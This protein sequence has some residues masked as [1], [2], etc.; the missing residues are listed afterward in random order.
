MNEF[1]T[2]EDEISENARADMKLLKCELFETY[3]FNHNCT[4]QVLQIIVLAA[5]DD[6]EL[7]IEY[8]DDRYD[9][10]EIA[11]LCNDLEA[12]LFAI[13]EEANDNQVDSLI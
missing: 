1:W 6:C 4:D 13:E 9:A 3:T 7:A 8:L 2:R 12:Y 11:A 10:K 5:A